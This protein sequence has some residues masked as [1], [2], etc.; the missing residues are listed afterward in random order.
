MLTEAKHL[1][2]S[3]SNKFL[4][5]AMTFAIKHRVT[6]PDANSED[7]HDATR[8]DPYALLPSPTT[9]ANIKKRMVTIVT[10]ILANN[11]DWLKGLRKTVNKPTEHEF[12]VHCA[13]AR[14]K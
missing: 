8:V 5:Q 13:N 9:A 12:T 10:R 2:T 11:I 7:V 6:F 1:S 14:K 4:L 3:N